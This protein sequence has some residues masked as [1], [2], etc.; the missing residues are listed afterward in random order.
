MDAVPSSCS[1]YD[2]G[3]QKSYS[4]VVSVSVIQSS[5]SSGLNFHVSVHSVLSSILR[6]GSLVSVLLDSEI[7]VIIVCFFL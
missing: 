4:S 7:R 5:G 2:E 3:V 1:P 6:Q